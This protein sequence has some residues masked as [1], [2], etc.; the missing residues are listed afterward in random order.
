MRD[1]F[2]KQLYQFWGQFQQALLELPRQFL[3]TWEQQVQTDLVISGFVG[4]QSSPGNQDQTDPDRIIGGVGTR[5]RVGDNSRLISRVG[6]QEFGNVW[7]FFGVE[8][9]LGRPTGSLPPLFPLLNPSQAM[10]A[11]TETITGPTEPI[12]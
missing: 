2:L 6:I 9:Q 4:H 1:Q 5:W 7:T 8:I 3:L 10:A 11:G 12:P